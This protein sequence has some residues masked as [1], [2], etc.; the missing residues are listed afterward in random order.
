MPSSTGSPRDG[1]RLVWLLGVWQTGEAARQRLAHQSRVAGASI[2]A[3]LPD[4]RDADVSRLAASRSATTTSTPTSAATRRWPACASACAQRGLRLML[5]FVPNHVAPDHPWVERAPG[6]L[7]RRHRGA[8]GARSRTTTARV[9][10]RPASRASSPT[11]ATRTSPAGPTRCS[12]TTATRRCRRRCSASCGGSPASAT[13]SAATWRC[14]CCPTSSSGPG[15]SRAAAVLAAGHGGGP[16]RVPGLPFMA[17]VYWD[18]EW[19]LQQQGFDYTYDKRLYDRLR[20]GHARPV[21]EHLLRRA[22]LPGPPGALP[23]EPRR[24]ARRGDVRARSAPGGRRVTFLTPGLRFFHQGQREGKRVRIPCI[25]A[26]GRSRPPTHAIARFLR[27]PARLP[28]DP[29]FRDGDW[30]LLEPR[31]AWDGWASRASL[32][33]RR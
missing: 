3:S 24:A 31:P 11:A 6:V 22:R 16:R 29:A 21:R 33:A 2:A 19:T 8:A 32:S 18:L 13:A 27:R 17:E 4:F 15:A 12:S 20:E 25:S 30:Q 28:K 10:T 9:E 1:L 7:R 23:R 14:W 26:A 5:D